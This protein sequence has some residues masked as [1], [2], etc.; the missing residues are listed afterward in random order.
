MTV[1]KFVNFW[2]AFPTQF[3]EW[4]DD[5]FATVGKKVGPFAVAVNY[6]FDEGDNVDSI[7]AN[8]TTAAV[9]VYLPRSP[10]GIR[11]RRVIKTDASANTVTVN[12]NAFLINGGA[13][14]V[15]AN[16]YDYVEVEPTG[17]GWLI[18]NSKP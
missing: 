9:T 2:P 8:A 12:G 4:L 16:Q 6:F 11:R 18:I 7:Q 14:V 1:R 3:L 15:L 5:N 17:T 10:T 13:T